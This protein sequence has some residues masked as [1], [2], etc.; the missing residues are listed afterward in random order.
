VLRPGGPLVTS[1]IHWMSLYRGGIA[2]AVDADGMPKRMP[3]SR[4]LPSDYLAAALPL[5]LRVRTLLEP[6]RPMEVIGGGPVADAYGRAA[7]VAAYENTPAA[8]I[9]EFELG[10]A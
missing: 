4:F 9:W 7:A 1:D 10:G 8:I 3:A 2:S 6:R 5:G